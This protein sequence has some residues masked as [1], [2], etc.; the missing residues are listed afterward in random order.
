MLFPLE[1]PD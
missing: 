1:A